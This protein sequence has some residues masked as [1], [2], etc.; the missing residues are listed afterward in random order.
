MTKDAA[1]LGRENLLHTVVKDDKS[2]A[3]RG[4][5]RQGD[6]NVN[7]RAYQLEMLEESL[8]TN[9]I[10]AVYFLHLLFLVLVS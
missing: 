1:I 3:T 6:G 7:S 9:I 8:K 10:V 4:G 2:C 5:E